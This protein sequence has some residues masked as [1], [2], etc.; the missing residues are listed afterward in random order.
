MAIAQDATSVIAAAATTS[1]AT[2]N[3]TCTGS[4]G[5][6]VIAIEANKTTDPV[7]NVTYSGSN[8][9]KITN[10]SIVDAT[11]GIVISYWYK[12]NPATGSNQVS[13]TWTTGASVN[14]MGGGESLTGVQQ[15]GQPDASGTNSGVTG[16]GGT[17]QPTVNITTVAANSWMIGAV[18]VNDNSA[19][20]AGAL[21]TKAFE[22]DQSGSPFHTVAGSYRTAL[23]IP[24]TDTINFTGTVNTDN[25]V[26]G[27]ASFAP[28]TSTTSTPDSMLLLTG[29]G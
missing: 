2:W 10:A 6:L 14:L 17:N 18:G 5:L 25:W 1:P 8:M 13:V 4:N 11:N 19:L 12:V 21:Q 27:A 23:A 16:V 3:H 7:T 29:V 9:T 22:L 20:S 24:G 26:I 28:F 15:S